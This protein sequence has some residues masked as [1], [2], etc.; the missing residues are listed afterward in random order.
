MST[1]NGRCF[2][3]CNCECDKVCTCS[4]KDHNSG[5]CP[6]YCCVLIE[7]RNY[8]YCGNKQPKWIFQH[9]NS[10]C[11][12]NCHVQ[13]GIHTYTGKIK[14]CCV[15]LEDKK[16]IILKCKHEI[17]NDCWYNITKINFGT[18]EYNP[19]CPMCRITSR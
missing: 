7:C 10:T 15:C 1:C 8:K 9:N 11:C 2:Y 17:C 16:M 19:R 13:M 6:S 12:F 3:R 4:H 14:N 5:Y 18:N